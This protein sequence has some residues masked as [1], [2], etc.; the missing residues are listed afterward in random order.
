MAGTDRET[1]G[2]VTQAEVDGPTVVVL[3]GVHR[4]EV[5]GYTA[6]G[7]IA[8]W[9]ITA[10]TLV[11]IPEVNVAAIERGTR[12]DE[13]GTDLNR[14]FPEG[15]SHEPTSLARSGTCSSSTNPTPSSTSRVGWGLHRRRRRRGRTSDF[16]LE[17]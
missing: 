13:E 15:G 16:P 10:G 17:R 1:T 8:D 4:N 6:A 9:E 5:A 7:K 12:T 11:T 2:Y 14:Q 3:G